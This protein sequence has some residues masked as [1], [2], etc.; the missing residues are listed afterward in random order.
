MTLKL[1]SS[2]PLLY[3][4][5]SFSLLLELKGVDG[6]AIPNC[7]CMESAVTCSLP[8]S[9]VVLVCNASVD[10]SDVTVEGEG[11][12]E[13]KFNVPDGTLNF[14][15]VSFDNYVKLLIRVSIPFFF[16]LL[17]PFPPPCCN[18]TLTP[19]P[20]PTISGSYNSNQP[21][22]RI[23]E[24]DAGSGLDIDIE[25]EDLRVSSDSL[26]LSDSLVD[27]S[28]FDGQTFGVFFF[29]FFFFFFFFLFF[30][31]FFLFLFIFLFIFLFPFSFS[32][33]FPLPFSFL[34][35]LSFFFPPKKS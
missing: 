19:S 3:F 21:V 15:D 12:L 9:G 23:D 5:L 35:L 2:F 14:F 20:Q 10:Y 4:F 6:V 34:F 33:P 32:T 25:M 31:F 7:G 17:P 24:F 30:S 11:T 29:S 18:K 13:I 26:F 1:P 8:P 22:V 28:R 16:S 27:I